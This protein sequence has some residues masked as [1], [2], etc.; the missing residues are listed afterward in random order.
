M[1]CGL[2]TRFSRIISGSDSAT[3]AIMNASRVPMGSP[4]SYRDCTSGMTPAALEYRGIPM[5]TATTTPSGLSAL[6]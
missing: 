4:A 5:R 2:S 1:S 6:A 3:T